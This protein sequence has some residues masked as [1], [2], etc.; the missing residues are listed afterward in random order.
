[1]RN[2]RRTNN[3]AKTSE[4]SAASTIDFSISSSAGSFQ[5]FPAEICVAKFDPQNPHNM[6]EICHR[7]ASHRNGVPPS[8]MPALLC[9]AAHKL[10]VRRLEI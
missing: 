6:R 5:S 7:Q 4:P 8:V 10:K 3:F 1:V 2:P 9:V